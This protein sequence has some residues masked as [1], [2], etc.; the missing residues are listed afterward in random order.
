MARVNRFYNPVRS[1]YQSQFVAKKLPADLLMRGLAGKQKKYDTTAEQMN[2][3]RDEDI[4]AFGADDTAY[5]K[6]KV[7]ARNEFLDSM[8]NED[9]GSS[10]AIMKYKNF[11]RDFKNDEGLKI[12]AKGL[13]DHRARQ[14]NK[15]AAI[16]NKTHYAE[17][18]YKDDA[19]EIEYARPGSGGGLAGLSINPNITPGTD[20]RTAIEPMFNN[21]S[22][23]GRENLKFLGETAYKNGWKGV[24]DEKILGAAQGGFE[25]FMRSLPGQ[26]ASNLYNMSLDRGAVETNPETGKPITE[27]QWMLKQMLGVG[28][29]KMFMTTTTNKDQA[30]NTEYGRLQK[31]KENVKIAQN[32]GYTKPFNIGKDV[33][34]TLDH[35]DDLNNKGDKY[36]AAVARTSLNDA[37]REFNKTLSPKEQAVTNMGFAEML[38]SKDGKINPKQAEQVKAVAERVRDTYSILGL[39]MTLPGLNTTDVDEMSYDEQVAFIEKGVK[40]DNGLSKDNIDDMSREIFAE[41]LGLDYNDILERQDDYLEK[42]EIYEQKRYNMPFSAEPLRNAA[43]GNLKTS[44]NAQNF[45]IPGV[46]ESEQDALFNKMK[47]DPKLK[48]M[49]INDNGKYSKPSMT[50]ST[51]ANG[52]YEEID[53]ELTGVGKNPN[54]ENTAEQVL[55]AFGNF[56]GGKEIKEDLKNKIMYFDVTAVDDPEVNMNDVLAP[57]MPLLR[58]TEWSNLQKTDKGLLLSYQLKGRPKS[59]MTHADVYEL[60]QHKGLQVPSEIVN[61]ISDGEGDAPYYFQ[62]KFEALKLGGAR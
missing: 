45:K 48:F 34:D 8:M 55:G 50:V 39:N 30:F 43:E 42:G 56:I 41:S 52:E 18:T 54:L 23:D 31:E 44:L 47:A 36:G 46:E 29:E 49:R 26:Q 38:K 19:A 53:I 5:A 1:G 32:T 24:T 17:Q 59:T 3:F 57:K 12:V 11:V 4:E 33:D 27:T 62:N 37:K 10:E 51:E 22:A 58:D 9:L 7:K 15:A 6:Q 16:K 21:L 13:A 60:Y 25:L 40:D 14:K 28:S 20:L 61:S 35:I 2:I